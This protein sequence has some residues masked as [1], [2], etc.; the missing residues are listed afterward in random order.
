MKYTVLLLLLFLLVSKAETQQPVEIFTYDLLP[1]YAFRNEAGQ[2]TG[3]YVEIVKTALSRMPGYSLSFN[4]VP[5]ARAK[6]AAKSGDA[7]AILPPYF[8]AHDWLTDTKPK[9]PYIWPYSLSIYTQQDIVICNTEK[10]KNTAMTF[11]IDFKGLSFVMWRGDGRAGVS[12]DDMVKQEEITVYLVDSIEVAVNLLVSGRFDCTVTS[13]LP[14][15]WYLA[16][17]LKAGAFQKLKTRVKLAKASTIRFNDV[18][19]GYSDI[20]SRQK[21]PFKKH[22]SILFDI[23]IY[24]MKQSGEIIEIAERF[25]DHQLIT[26]IFS[27]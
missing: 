22:F 19:L 25:I 11:P 5:W 1:P 12:F 21:Y 17:K 10:L 15:S 14:F 26:P 4:V 18:Y 23:E 20:N 24:K 13:A 2:L 7:F 8:H 9:R 3:I 27:P 16:K 6:S